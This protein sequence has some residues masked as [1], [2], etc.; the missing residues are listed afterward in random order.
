MRRPQMKTAL[1]LAIMAAIVASDASA[2]EPRIMWRSKETGVIAST[3]PI[4]IPPP[5]STLGAD[6][7]GQRFTWSK[8]DNVKLT[9]NVR[10]GNGPLSWAISTGTPLP[11]GVSLHP[12]TGVISGNA[13]TTG[14]FQ[15]SILITDE[16]TGGRVTAVAVF[17]VVAG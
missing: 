5:V 15:V 7:R 16:T 1:P 13:G 4:I 9:P 14:R 12:T 11:A 2:Q 8:G 6:Y 17:E 3:A 10:G